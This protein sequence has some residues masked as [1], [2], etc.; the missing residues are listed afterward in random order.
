MGGKSKKKSTVG[1][2]Y[3]T[4]LHFAICHGEIDG[5][6]S[7][8]WA[9]KVYWSGFVGKSADGSTSL[10]YVDN[11]G[12][13]G[14]EM[15]EGGAEGRF[16]FGAGSY[17]QTLI[18]V[19]PNGT[20][21]M[22]AVQQIYPLTGGGLKAVQARNAKVP[23][24]AVNYRG[25]AVVLLHDNYVGNNAYLKDISFEVERYWKEWQPNLARIGDNMNPA[26]II[27]EC[28]TNED[29]GLGYPAS[30]ID[31]T[32]FLRAAQTLYNEQF[33][34]SFV[35]TSEQDMMSFIEQVKSTIDAS[36]YLDRRSGLWTLQLI[37]AGDQSVMTLD[38]TNSVL[39][40]FS[41]KVMGETFN[42]L[43]VK[44]TNPENEE[45]ETITVQD[46]ANIEAQGR[47]IQT[48]KEY[49]G[50]RT[51]ALA[52]RIAERD[53][54][55]ASAQLATAEVTV[56]R[57]G[58]ALAPGQNVVLNWP[59]LG[60]YGITM[61]VIETTQAEPGTDSIR[62]Q[63][64]EDVFGRGGGSF[65]G[66]PGSGFEDP[67]QPPVLFPRTRAWEMPFAYVIRNAEVPGDQLPTL[68]GYATALVAGGV[69][70]MPQVRLSSYIS[71]ENGLAWVLMNVGPSTPY[72]ALA[73][74][75][76]AQITSTFNLDAATAWHVGDAQV[77]SFALIGDATREE[78]VQVSAISSTGALTVRRGLMDT[79]PQAWPAGTPLYFVGVDLFTADTSQR[80]FGE[81]VRY[82]PAMQTASG[83]L[84]LEAVPETT[85]ALKG[86]YELPYPPA[87]VTIG[88]SYW[89]GVVQP[90][91][92]SFTVAWATRNRLLQDMP[93]QV[94]WDAP[95]IAPEANT[96]F[97]YQLLNENGTVSKSGSGITA[98]SVDIPV[99][100]LT[101]G[102]YTLV[103]WSERD[104]RR[105]F[106]D[107]R[108]SFGLVT[109]VFDE[110]Y[111][112]SYGFSYG[113]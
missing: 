22:T 60:L 77:N 2:K 74:S 36:F 42:E 57:E 110:G 96:T 105:N 71:T 83:Y 100:G 107:F 54:R 32:S 59:P 98:T 62:L 34:L 52:I 39:D 3:Y 10:T 40:S 102:L 95:A 89:P 27:Y 13:F 63:L 94:S 41:R 30:D 99:S 65:A 29:W 87:N 82:K 5:I 35:W 45:Y 80:S 90:S 66:V 23:P 111:G 70:S 69:T 44:W 97:G 18:G 49:V 79:S 38:P 55:V 7:I 106:L 61:R 81:V 20:Y 28:L 113:L 31:Q 84:E 16:E 86:R 93:E 104:G 1:F 112:N 73:S 26:H 51:A 88:G 76:P 14:G 8:W 56:N 19:L 9:D 91:G 68:A 67:N 64:G 103:L 78:V 50:V 15:S 43:S 33:G 46:P 37:R 24:M 108:H 85:L 17:Q 4:N 47:V 101:T 6:R 53:L 11:S 72:G 21:D 25:L 12:M 92:S 75:L 109:P 58:W 48:D